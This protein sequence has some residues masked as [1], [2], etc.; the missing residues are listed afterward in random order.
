MKK[1]KKIKGYNKHLRNYITLSMLVSLG[2][3]M[4][5]GLAVISISNSEVFMFE[6]PFIVY[7]LSLF[8][9]S[10]MTIMGL[11]YFNTFNK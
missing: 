8:I 3:M 10:M 11:Y 2:M 4:F 5:I 9:F 1:Q 7:T 6:I